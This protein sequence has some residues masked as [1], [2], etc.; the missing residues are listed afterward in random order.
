M[1]G[2]LALLG[3]P[4]PRVRK[5]VAEALYVRL[6]TLDDDFTL[7]EAPAAPA[8]SVAAGGGGAGGGAPDMERVLAILAD[9]AWDGP[10]AAARA[11]RDA[12]LAALRIELSKEAAAA[13]AA[14]AAEGSSGSASSRHAG[15]G[16]SGLAD[17]EDGTYG[18]LVR[19]M[20]Y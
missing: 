8:S 19:E 1:Q 6:L 4:F 9:T 10:V 16:A 12:L 15:G 14:A 2:A 7:L 3:H 20:G 17:E 13:E 11:Q 5:A 18:A